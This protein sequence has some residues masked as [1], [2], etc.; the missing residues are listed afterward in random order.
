MPLQS[1][2]HEQWLYDR[3]KDCNSQFSIRHLV[4]ELITLQVSILGP[5]KMGILTLCNY[6]KFFFNIGATAKYS[7]Q[8]H[9]AA[10]LEVSLL[11]KIYGQILG[12]GYR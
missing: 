3:S 4:E 12:L 10:R 8:Y 2:I 6:T 7:P 9:T 11:N 1:N 5:Q